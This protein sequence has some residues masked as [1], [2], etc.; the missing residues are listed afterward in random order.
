MSTSIILL[1]VAS[2]VI[3]AAWNALVK[4][5]QDRLWSIAVISLFG[6]IA[7]LPF[8]IGFGPPDEAS[9]PYLLL[10]AGIQIGYCLFLVRAYEHGDLAQVYPIARGSAPLLVTI[11]ATLFAGELPTAIGLAGIA[12]VSTG[13][14]ALASGKESAS[15]KAVLLALS[16]GAFIASYM[17]VDGLGVRLSRN[18][19]GYAAWQATLAG[20]VIPLAFIGIRRRLFKIPRGREGSTLAIA[21]ALSALA[22]CVAVWAMNESPMGGVSALR[23]TSILFATV[24]G[25]IFL[26]EKMTIRVVSGA[27]VITL[28]VVLLSWA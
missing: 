22:Y 5:G 1:L 25:T 6:S 4:S 18:A 7:A 2:A 23:E 13:I 10:S 8:A 14:F 17:V 20:F 15:P 16:T 19:A 11:G 24:I 3:H 26:R 12:L 21:G 27:I 9:V 28:G